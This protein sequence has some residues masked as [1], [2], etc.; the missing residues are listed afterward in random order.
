MLDINDAIE[1]VGR[2]AGI[3]LNTLATDPT[4]L[5]FALTQV[6]PISMMSGQWRL[7]EAVETIDQ[8]LADHR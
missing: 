3:D 1:R 4:W 2:V 7:A 6:R 5:D 8:Y